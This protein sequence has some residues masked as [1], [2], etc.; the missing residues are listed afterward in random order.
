L[1]QSEL[2]PKGP[3]YTNLQSFDLWTS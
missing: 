3:I 1:M 2:T